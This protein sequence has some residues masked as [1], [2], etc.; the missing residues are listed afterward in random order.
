[1][2]RNLILILIPAAFLLLITARSVAQV[3]ITDGSDLTINP[4]SLLELES[5]DK[6]LLF[7]RVALSSLAS[8]SPL[9][10]P[11]P[12][13]MVVYSSGGSVPDGFY[14]WDGARWKGMNPSERRMMAPVSVSQDDTL[15]MM[16]SVI[17]ASND[18]TLTLPDLSG[19]DS[20][21]QI[22]VKNTG[23]NK[24]LVIVRGNASALIDGMEEA[25]IRPKLG[26]TFINNGTEWIIQNREAGGDEIIDVGPDEP[27]STISDA[28][29]FLE[30]HMDLPTV[31]RLSGM[32]MVMSETEIIDLPYPLTIQGTSYGSGTIAA[33]PGLAGKPM[34][35]CKSECYFKMLV[36]DATTLAGYGT[37][38]GEDAIRLVGSGTYNEIKDCTFEGFHNTIVDSTDAELWLFEC[39]ILDA[40]NTGLLL[41]SQEPGS[42][43]RVSETDFIRCKTGVCLSK[44]TLAEI[45]LI[46]GFYENDDNGS[47][48]CYDPAAFSFSSLIMTNNAWNYRGTAMTG[49]DFSRTDGRD[50]EAFVENNVGFVSNKPHGK[51]NV[52]NNSTQVTCTDANNWYKAAWTN[53]SDFNTNLRIENNKV[54]FLPTSPRDVNIFISGNVMEDSNNRVITIAIVKNGNTA[55]RYGETSLRVTVAN[56]PFQFST[57][58]HLENVQKNDYLEMYCSSANAGDKLT[59]QDINWYISA[60]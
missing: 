55:V 45:Q 39:D 49:F 44:G 10:A 30:E 52:V 5:P 57:I 22:T 6:G 12:V 13:A 25:E 16:C 41:H 46:S 17:F 20:T 3:K 2:N 38:P 50:A 34:F 60:E 7:P 53:T 19:T 42:K 15:Q 27:F 51:I 37:T 8:P 40:S 23:S 24:D 26:K 1:M 21:V 58:I 47:A 54:T 43:I 56:Q 48:I 59:F 14:F 31:I 33:G 18:I 4:N 29:E 36:F 9:I 35:R 32:T 11:V 28:L